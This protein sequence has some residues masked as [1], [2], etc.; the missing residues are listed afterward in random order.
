[1][2]KITSQALRSR[3]SSTLHQSRR[4]KLDTR[5]A[6]SHLA[7]TTVKRNSSCCGRLFELR[8]PQGSRDTHQCCDAVM[9]QGTARSGQ[10]HTEA[11]CPL[12][13]LHST[14]MRMRAVRTVW[15][16]SQ[17]FKKNLKKS[18]AETFAQ[19]WL[20]CRGQRH[21]LAQ[22]L[23]KGD[24]SACLWVICAGA[25]QKHFTCWHHRCFVDQRMPSPV[26]RRI[27]VA[28]IRSTLDGF[29]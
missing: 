14:H 12:E 13:T 26:H 6:R 22:A 21:H 9:I 25:R 1:V 20:V 16:Q 2:V 7:L 29:E 27:F 8:A 28:S 17:L 4:H 10:R 23:G 11:I 3:V 19:L 15:V 18:K 24:H 5:A